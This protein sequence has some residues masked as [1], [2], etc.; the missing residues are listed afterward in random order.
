M[1]TDRREFL[2][3]ES[4][5]IAG[6]PL[7]AQCSY[8]FGGAKPKVEATGGEPEPGQGHVAGRTPKKV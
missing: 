5:L 6:L 4:G 2:T 8:K 3:A 1:K 7:I